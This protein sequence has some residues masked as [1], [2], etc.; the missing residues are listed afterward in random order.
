MAYYYVKSGGTATADA[1][2]AATKRTGSFAT[3]GASAYYDSIYDVFAG[4]VPTTAPVAADFVLASD[5]HAKAHTVLLTMNLNAGAIISVDDANAETYKKGATESTTNN[6]LSAL[7]TTAASVVMIGLIIKC[8]RYLKIV[9]A[10]ETRLTAIDCDFEVTGA[11]AGYFLCAVGDGAL[12]V[13]KNVTF[14]HGNAG[15]FFSAA[16]GG[17]FVWEGGSLE[18]ATTT[19]IK[20]AGNGGGNATISDVDLLNVTS[21]ITDVITSSAAD[22]VEIDITRSLLTSGVTLSSG[23]WAQKSSRIEATLLAY[24]TDKDDQHHYAGEFYEGVYSRETAIYRTAGADYGAGDN[25]S[26]EIV[27]NANCNAA[28]P[29]GVSLMAEGID[30]ADYTT[31][32]TFKAHFAVDGSTTAL[33]SDEFW[34]EIEHADGLDNAL[35]SIAD[36][37]T[38]PPTAGT[39]PTT[40]TALWT[41]LGGTNKQMSISK[42][43]TIG[44][45]AGTI[46]SG[47]VRVKAYLGKASQTVFVCPQVEIS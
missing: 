1:G 35:G 32:I 3:M 19:L 42:T 37:R 38:F 8:V 18:S 34:L 16:S 29:V 14:T 26:T 15:S 11:S 36:N 5:L 24:S 4:G 31:D 45:T 40:E 46:A 28:N 39:A 7:S 6:T 33:N 30:T 41:G 9:N 25:L 17:R 23:A 44:T 27:A 13:Y 20:S 22:R 43:I 10:A 21:T 2:R 47:I 12:G